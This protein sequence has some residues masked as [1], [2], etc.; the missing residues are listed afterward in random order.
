M[1]ARGSRLLLVHS[2]IFRRE[3][4]RLSTP[5]AS[6]ESLR[7]DGGRKDVEVLPG[8]PHLP[9]LHLGQDAVVGERFDVI[10]EDRQAQC[11]VED[12]HQV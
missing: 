9:F 5:W 2:L 6:L 12:E 7:P 3:T 1:P 10:R 4:A 8:S 11:L